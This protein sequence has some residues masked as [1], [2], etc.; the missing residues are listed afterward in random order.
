MEKIVVIG[1]SGTGKTTLTNRLAE[2]FNARAIDL[3]DHYWR[4]GWQP[5]PVD[6]FRDTVRRAIDTPRW[7]AAGNYP[8]VRDITWAQADT[9]VWLDYSLARTFNQLAQRSVRRIWDKAPICNGNT[10]TF[11]K[12]FST[13][14]ILYWLLAT[15]HKRKR[16]NEDIFAH[17]ER[18][19]HIRNFV[20]LKSPAE[21][22]AFLAAALPG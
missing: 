15:Y 7:V 10:E 11:G 16:E 17:P 21:T 2:K 12:V 8:A 20:R 22:Q 3:D 9:L 1:S 6:E 19:P 18:Y 5:A 14:G 4:P 13:D